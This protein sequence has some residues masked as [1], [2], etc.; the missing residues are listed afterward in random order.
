MSP[1]I[2]SDS[3]YVD[4]IK[5]NLKEFNVTLSTDFTTLKAMSAKHSNIDRRTK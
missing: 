5:T 2:A 3:A 4:K 1:E